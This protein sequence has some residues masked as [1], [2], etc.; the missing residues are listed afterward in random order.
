MLLIDVNPQGAMTISLDYQEPD[1]LDNTL[2]DLMTA[3]VND[4]LLNLD[5]AIRHHHEGVKLIPANID[6]SDIEI[7]PVKTLR[8]CRYRIKNRLPQPE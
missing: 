6:L 5:K 1:E 3:I 8:R 2:A 7:S 4:D